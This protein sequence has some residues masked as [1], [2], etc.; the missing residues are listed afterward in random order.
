M[1]SFSEA[2]S[3]LK[4][5]MEASQSANEN[6]GMDLH[7]HGDDE[8]VAQPVERKDDQAL[9]E[10][11]TGT[12]SAPTSPRQD[13]EQQHGLEVAISIANKTHKGGEYAKS[14]K[15][16]KACSRKGLA[17]FLESRP[18]IFTLIGL[19][20]L[21]ILLVSYYIELIPLQNLTTSPHM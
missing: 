1:V 8:D 15:K 14:K 13:Q 5:V 4:L 21:D 18:V 20:V 11:K 9:K 3:A 16:A 2:L 7:R 12:S 6:Q 17:N 10:R 19:L